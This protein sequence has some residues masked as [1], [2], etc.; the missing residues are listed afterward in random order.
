M[1]AVTISAPPIDVTAPRWLYIRT[2]NGQHPTPMFLAGQYLE[3]DLPELF[4]EFHWSI[5]REYTSF[6]QITMDVW[7]VKRTKKRTKK[8]A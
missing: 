5:D 1:E 4:G 6:H 2:H 7:G 3:A 8:V